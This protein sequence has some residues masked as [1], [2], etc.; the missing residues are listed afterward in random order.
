ME[1][2]KNDSLGS[3]DPLK[4]FGF[5]FMATPEAYGISQARGRI[6]AAAA[7][8]CHTATATPDLTRISD[9]HH[10]LWQH[11]ILNPL[12]EASDRTCVLTDTML[13]SKPMEPPSH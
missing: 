11:R 12:S 13:G 9:L 10:S 4:I 7:G 5:L 3:R 1:D 6:G 8:L 2:L